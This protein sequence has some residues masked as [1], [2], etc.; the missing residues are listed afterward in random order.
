MD[1]LQNKIMSEMVSNHSSALERNF[2][3]AKK[4]IKIC[5]SGTV[6]IIEK[7]KYTGEELI[8]LY[9]IGKCYAKEAGF[10]NSNGVVNKELIDELG[11]S[12]GS[13]FPWLKNLRDSN[14]IKQNKE[15]SPIEHF[16]PI[17]LVE[18]TLTK[19]INK[20]NQND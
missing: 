16:I 3:L 20:S 4:L 7:N 12:E 17:N 6:E 18:N 8:L 14:K 1:S 19:L 11:K 13:I 9:L 5:Q 15:T 10:T 2:D